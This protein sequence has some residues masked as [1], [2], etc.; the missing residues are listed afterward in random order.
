MTTDILSVVD[1]ETASL[2]GFCKPLHLRGYLGYF[3]IMRKILELV[4]S[5]TD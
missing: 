3:S 1:F 5:N 2:K 4:V